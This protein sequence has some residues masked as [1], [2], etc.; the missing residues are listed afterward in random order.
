MSINSN[1]TDAREIRERAAKVRSRWS[2]IDRMRRTGLPPD[3][4]GNLQRQLVLL[5]ALDRHK[6]TARRPRRMQLLAAVSNN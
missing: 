6:V 1:R 3:I 5:H 4:P 2:D